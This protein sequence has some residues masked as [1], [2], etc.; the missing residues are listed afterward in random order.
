MRKKATGARVLSEPTSATT[1]GGARRVSGVELF[2]PRG[3]QRHRLVG[4]KGAFAR[5]SQPE[6]GPAWS[7]KRLSVASLDAASRSADVESSVRL[8]GVP[9][10]RLADFPGDHPGGPSTAW[11]A[12]MGV[13]GAESTATTASSLSS[14]MLSRCEPLLQSRPWSGTKRPWARAGDGR[15]KRRA[16]S[17]VSKDFRGKDQFS[18]VLG[19]S[20]TS[21]GSCARGSS[22]TGESLSFGISFP[23]RVAGSSRKTSSVLASDEL[24]QRRL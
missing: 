6:V 18:H 13:R 1:L 17:T 5:T 7:G 19:P 22:S 10:K 12:G 24:S 15:G 9:G 14:R 21:A 20:D 2:N 11:L 3:C 8:V 23:L 4:T 16:G